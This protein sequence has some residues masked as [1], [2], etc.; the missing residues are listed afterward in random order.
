MNTMRWLFSASVFY[1]LA[2][3]L[4]SACGTEAP[5]MGQAIEDRDSMPVMVTYGVSKLISDSGV[6][7]YKIVS[8]EWAVYD[9]T[10]PPRQ[11]FLKGIFLEQYDEKFNPTLHIT[12]DTAFCYNQKLW[13]LRGR[14]VIRNHKKKT[15]FRTEELYWDMREHK[16]HSNKHMKIVTP[17]REIEGDCFVSNEEMTQYHISQSR[18]SIPMP[19]E[20]KSNDST[21]TV[22]S[23]P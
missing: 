4:P 9:R 6:I 3:L 8:E 1:L 19:K 15:I 12:A 2:V 18:G 13:E 16:V 5:P 20:N 11:E 10:F 7:K 14:V 22:A 21:K 17:D 23:Q